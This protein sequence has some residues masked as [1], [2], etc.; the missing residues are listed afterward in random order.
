MA[1]FRQAA[2]DELSSPEQLD[3]HLELI[4]PKGWLAL[5]G[6]FSLI[7]CGIVWSIVGSLPT[8]VEGRGILLKKGGLTRVNALSAGQLTEITVSPS[9]EVQKGQVLARLALPELHVE[10]E[11][12]QASLANLV[13]QNRQLTGFGEGDIQLEKTVLMEKRRNAKEQIEIQN[14]RAANLSRKLAAQKRLLADG[15]I[16]EQAVQDTREKLST[17]QADAG[18]LR[19]TLTELVAKGTED[20]QRKQQDRGDRRIRIEELRRRTKELTGKI[21]RYSALIS[22]VRGRVL[23][24]RAA[25][26]TLVTPGMPILVLENSGPSDPSQPQAQGL[27]AIVYV[28]AAEG[29]KVA[30]G[31]TVLVAPSTVV[32]EQYGAIQGT[33]TA[34]AEYPTSADAI[35]SRLGSQELAASFLKAVET[36]LEVRIALLFDSATK[37]GYKWTSPKGPPHKILQ[38]TL[39]HAWVTIQTRAPISLVLPILQGES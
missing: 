18:R 21:E 4:S 20:L 12:A 34:V 35:T 27:E 9:A 11:G 3:L 14:E 24:L 39:C 17:A 26:G 32:R 23:E 33:V 22:P 1:I 15:L 5:I 13:S 28:P 7:A 25:V 30:K 10:L 6:L 31:M 16:T 37:S 29:K 19:G 38:G 2:L 8:R 36:P